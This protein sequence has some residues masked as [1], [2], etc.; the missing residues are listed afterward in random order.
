MFVVTVSDISE[1][2][3]QK[4]EL[5]DAKEAAEKAQ[6]LAEQ[7]AAAKAT[8]LANMS[9][10][11]RTPMN[12]VMGLLDL[13]GD[14]ELSNQQAGMINTAKV[15]AES[16]LNLLNDILDISKI[17]AGKIDLE[18]TDFELGC[19]I[20]EVVT[21][22]HVSAVE[23]GLELSCFVD[24]SIQ[25]QVRGDPTRLRQ[26]ASNIIGNAVKF[27]QEGEVEVRL[28]LGSASSN[29]YALSLVVRDTGIGM[30]GEAMTSLFDPFSQAD[31]STTRKFGGTGL[32]MA[33]SRQLVELM[34]GTISAE[35]ELG[36]GTT[37][38]VDIDLPTCEA[39]GRVDKNRGPLPETRMLVVSDNSITREILGAY[40]SSWGIHCELVESAYTALERITIEQ[41]SPFDIC[42]IDRSIADM[43]GVALA[44]KIAQA[45]GTS[46]MVLALLKSVS[47]DDAQM[48]NAG[49]SQTLNKPIRQA[50]LFDL[51][52]R[53]RNVEIGSKEQALTEKELFEG[54]VLLVEDNTVNQ[55][56]AK[57]L[58]EKMGLSVDIA[59]DG[60]KSLEA[61]R[62]NDYDLV[63]MDCLMP[64]M[65]GYEATAKRLDPII[66]GFNEAAEFLS[67]GEHHADLN[68]V[69]LPTKA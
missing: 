17:E 28:E 68:R 34:G 16:L 38:R 35:T 50:E 24:P 19:L 8:F 29:Q 4:A 60:Q 56:V 5:V 26:I 1:Q 31:T 45:N 14:T 63:F 40:L 64:V 12:G 48:E 66:L 15:S 47:A 3:R 9:H 2:E 46:H 69:A 33:I 7:A 39:E 67:V 37:F 36:T 42:L 52:A 43:D 20:E 44:R 10:E 59:V 49:V 13:V 32:G 61:M 25:K 18:H 41:R 21:L 62:V 6:N 53:C 54:R 30:A 51:I 58:L 27:T 23:K 55:L 65:D 22:F 11:I 57:S